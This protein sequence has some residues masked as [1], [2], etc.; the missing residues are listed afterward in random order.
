[1]HLPGSTDF[2][3]CGLSADGM[4]WGL[5]QA[6]PLTDLLER[7]TLG[8][9]LR[10][11]PKGGRAAHGLTQEPSAPKPPLTLG[12]LNSGS[13]FSWRVSGRGQG[14][15][16]SGIFWSELKIE[17]KKAKAQSKMKKI[18]PPA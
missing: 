10:F 16:D 13:V 17:R 5:W 1:M 6:L 18:K 3:S 11:P 4:G 15:D 7:E 9:V 12:S 8:T 14:R 2:V